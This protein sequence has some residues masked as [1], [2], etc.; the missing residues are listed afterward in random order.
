MRVE[1]AATDE[2]VASEQVDVAEI[3]AAHHVGLVRLALM[4]VGDRPTAEDV[5]QEAFERTHAGRRRLRDPA[6]GLAYVRSAVLNGC[7]SVLRKRA[8]AFRRGVPYEPPIWS[9]EST[10]LIAEERRE[11]LAAL[12]RLPRRQR[13]ALILRYYLDLSDQEIA[14]VMSIG[15]STVR[16][17]IARGL[18]A[19][20]RNLGEEA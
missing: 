13:E 9:A 10:V 19:L 11:V 15:A 3:F 20:G 18:A 1:L 7:R 14:D 2:P 6:K 4:L 5:V 16:S 8:F 17:T 12:Q